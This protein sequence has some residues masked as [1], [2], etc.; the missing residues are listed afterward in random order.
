MNFADP[1]FL[2]ILAVFVITVLLAICRWTWLLARAVFDRRLTR[3]HFVE[4]VALSISLA[5]LAATIGYTVCVFAEAA[6]WSH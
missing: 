2:G 5:S 3:K 6:S 4:L 1:V